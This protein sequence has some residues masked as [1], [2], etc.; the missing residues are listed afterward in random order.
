[1][2]R[3]MRWTRR[4]EEA[5]KGEMVVDGRQGRSG[6][7]G[8]DLLD[9]D[10]AQRSDRRRLG[11]AAHSSTER[12]MAPQASAAASASSRARPFQ[13]A[14]R[15]A[16]TSVGLSTAQ[17]R[18]SQARS[19]QVREL[20][21]EVDEAAVSAAVELYQG[22]VQRER[23]HGRVPTLELLEGETH[24]GG[25]GVTPRDR[26]GLGGAGPFLPQEGSRRP[27]GTQDRGGTFHHGE[28]RFERALL[29]GQDDALGQG[30]READ[31][32]EQTLEGRG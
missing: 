7:L 31:L 5:V 22:S 24:E 9:A 1:M 23:R 17:P 26:D 15:S 19:G 29:S 25:T 4:W 6:A 32:A 16:T 2:T 12:A 14:T 20:A 30:G 8:A 27:D 28:G 18:T 11:W 3:T 10:P 13:P 21:L